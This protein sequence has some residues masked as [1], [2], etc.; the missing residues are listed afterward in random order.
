[1]VTTISAWQLCSL[2]IVTCEVF[3]LLYSGF[4][5][6]FQI[7]YP[8]KKILNIFSG[9]KNLNLCLLL[10]TS[11]CTTYIISARLA[12]PTKFWTK[13]TLENFICWDDF[14]DSISGSQRN[15]II[16]SSLK[17]TLNAPLSGSRLRLTGNR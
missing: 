1:M 3:H 17:T 13:W 9:L 10:C 15:A 6:Y 8:L 7:I 16:A 11:M 4:V 14:A 2:L 5:F 12:K